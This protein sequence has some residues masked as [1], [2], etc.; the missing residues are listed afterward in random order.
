MWVSLSG[1]DGAEVEFAAGQVDHGA[2]VAHVLESAG[3]GLDVLDDAVESFEDRVGVRV[4]EVGEDVPPVAAY[5]AGELF[6][7]FE[8][9]A[10]HPRAQTLEG[11]L[12]L[13]SIGAGVVDVLEG[14]AHLTGA[15]GFQSSPLQAA[16]G[17]Q[18]Q[19]GQ[20]RFVPQPQVLGPLEQRVAA[21]LLFA[22]LVDGLVGVFDHV[23]L[24]DDSRRVGQPLADAL[25]EPQAHVAGNQTHPVGIAVVVHE[26]P[27]EPFDRGRVLARDHADYVALHQ[28]GDHGDVPVALPAGLVDAYGLHAR[29]VLVKPRLVH[30]MADEPPQAGVMFADLLGDVRDR[31]AFGQLHDH[32]L[33]QEREPASR[34]RPRHRDRVH[35]VG[36]ARHARHARVNERLVLEEVQMPPHALPRVMHRTRGLAA[37]RFRAGEPRT[38]REPDRDMQFPSA[39]LL[40][41]ELHARHPPRVRQL[42]GGGEQRRGIHTPKLPDQHHHPPTHS[43]TPNSERLFVFN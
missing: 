20:V 40:V 24:V 36:G 21:G 33:E 26:I 10:R 7:G 3:S 19:A 12:G 1:G 42:Q 32:R 5:L 22:D 34:P 41:T 39:V 31:L 17:F 6:H 13:G 2:E 15:S 9:G 8:S 25:G 16:L 11:R 43:P 35:A 23:E 37:P 28:V 30:V 27:R 4:V 38:R 18:L 14:L 29:V